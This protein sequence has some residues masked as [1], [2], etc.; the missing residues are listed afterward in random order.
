MAAKPSD[1]SFGQEETKVFFT[2]TYNI[3]LLL[4]TTSWAFFLSAS[5][6]CDR[7]LFADVEGTVPY[8]TLSEYFDSL[9]EGSKIVF[10]VLTNGT[11]VT[12]GVCLIR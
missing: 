6:P 9:G 1:S 12:I 7:G 4:A 11:S 8:N 3:T 5:W 2:K 10:G